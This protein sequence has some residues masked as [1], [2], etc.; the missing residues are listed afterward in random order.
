VADLAA[1]VTGVL[2]GPASCQDTK[3][4]LGL[5]YRQ[6]FLRLDLLRGRVVLAG[7]L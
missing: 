1:L 4:W 2:L 5:R 3:A 6:G 7:H